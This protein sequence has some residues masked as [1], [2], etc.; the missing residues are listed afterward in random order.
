RI[1]KGRIASYSIITPTQWNLGNGT[2]TNP[3][4]A[5]KAMIGAESTAKASLLFR[6]FDVCSVCTTH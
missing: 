5:Q 2:M 4:T 1:E 6:T 3:G